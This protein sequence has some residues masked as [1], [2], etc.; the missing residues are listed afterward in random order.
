MELQRSKVHRNLDLVWKIG[1]L[2]ALDLI[3]TLLLSSIMNLIFGG[4][5]LEFY[6]VIGLPMCMALILYFSKRN[7]PPKYLFHFLR[8]YLTQGFYSAGQQPKHKEKAKILIYAK[9]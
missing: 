3:S 4:T 6:L 1:G 8:F 7:K 9:Q 2:E 5:A